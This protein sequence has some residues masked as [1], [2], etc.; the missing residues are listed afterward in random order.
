MSR[1][2]NEMKIELDVAKLPHMEVQ[3]NE[4]YNHIFFESNWF[5]LSIEDNINVETFLNKIRLK[6]KYKF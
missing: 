6:I 2:V 4:L 1:L 5:G 3:T